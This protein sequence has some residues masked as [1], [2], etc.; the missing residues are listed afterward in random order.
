MEKSYF[1]EVWGE[2]EGWCSRESG[3]GFGVGLGKVIRRGWDTINRR[4][5]SNVGNNRRVQFWKNI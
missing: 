3:D 2:G 4:T 1:W 5:F